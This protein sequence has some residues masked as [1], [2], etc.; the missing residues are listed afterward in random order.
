MTYDYIKRTYKLQPEI[1]RRVQHTVTLRHGTITRE[2]ESAGH[3][4][5]V[6]FDGRNFSD[7]CHP[8]ELEYVS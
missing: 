8:D 7:S 4:V 6:R 3:Y 2:D 5:Q 1:G